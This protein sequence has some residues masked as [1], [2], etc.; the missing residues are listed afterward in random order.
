MACIYIPTKVFGGFKII[1]IT[2]VFI[3][4]TSFFTLF[5]LR[6]HI[7]SN[8]DQYKCNPLVMPFA[9]MFGF[10][11]TQVL[12]SCIGYSTRMSTQD[13]K[14]DVSAK[15]TKTD[16][17]YDKITA[18]LGL[19]VSELAETNRDQESEWGQYF[20]TLNNTT[21][22]MDYLGIKVKSIFFKIVAIYTTLLYAAYSMMQGMN[23]IIND[24]KLVTA[25]DIIVDPGRAI[26]ADKALKKLKKLSKS[27]GKGVKNAFTKK[28]K[29]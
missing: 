12:N 16:A 10:D 4:V 9:E 21:S 3:L 27:I 25:M 5:F 8:W 14:K 6:T 2:F 1:L 24:K 7:A 28:K 26:K 15:M 17:Q 23:G 29:K 20:N 22:T 18:G 19:L 13:L 11:S